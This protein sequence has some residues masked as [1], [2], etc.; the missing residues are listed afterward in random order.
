[1]QKKN[2]KLECSFEN[3]IVGVRPDFIAFSESPQFLVLKIKSKL[4]PHFL[5]LNTTYF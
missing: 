3:K 5:I 4:L 2:M 1:M